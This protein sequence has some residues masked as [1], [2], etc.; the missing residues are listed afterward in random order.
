MYK[1]FYFLKRPTNPPGHMKVLLLHRNHQH[2][3]AIYA[4]NLKVVRQFEHA[5]DPH[6][7]VPCLLSKKEDHVKP[8][9]AELNPI[10]YLLALLGTTH[11]LHISRIRVN[12]CQ[13]PHQRFQ[14]DQ[15]YHVS[16]FFP[17]TQDGIK[18]KI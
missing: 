17:E 3:S 18:M 13:D 12:M 9:R 15:N 11:I 14:R 16:S 2:V 5:S 6:H 1:I 7:I 8:L 4:V 10:C